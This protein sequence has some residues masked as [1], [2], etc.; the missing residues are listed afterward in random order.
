VEFGDAH[1]S[2]DRALTGWLGLDA[3]AHF[4]LAAPGAILTRLTTRSC[5]VEASSRTEPASVRVVP[6]CR[7]WGAPTGPTLVPCRAHRARLTC[8]NTTRHAAARRSRRSALEQTG[9]LDV[10][11]KRRSRQISQEP[12]T[13][14]A[15]QT[16]NS[17]IGQSAAR[18]ST[19]AHERTARFMRS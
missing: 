7:G 1:C 15:S 18:R 13:Q 6:S 5:I 8:N 3:P 19:A 9:G 14:A 16:A 17:G 11:T 12:Q 4:D 10:G 2:A